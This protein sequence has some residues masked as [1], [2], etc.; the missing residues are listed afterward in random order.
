MSQ[1]EV[2]AVVGQ[3]IEIL[4]RAQPGVCSMEQRRELKK[5]A[6]DL[7]KHIPTKK[8]ARIPD[9]LCQRLTGLV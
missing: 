8:M 6:F 9:D 1:K 3:A 4:E 2:N 7:V 5:Q